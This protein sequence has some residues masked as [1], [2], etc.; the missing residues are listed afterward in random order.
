M[1]NKFKNCAVPSRPLLSTL[2]VK[3]EQLNSPDTN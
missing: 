1:D 3:I 2:Y